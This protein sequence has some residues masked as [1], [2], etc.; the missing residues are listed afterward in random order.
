MTSPA[1]FKALG[2]PIRYQMVERLLEESPMAVGQVTDGLELTRQGA[3]RQLQV[4]V[5]SGLVTLQPRG[6]EVIASLE[7]RAL[8][9]MRTMVDELARRWDRRLESLRRHVEE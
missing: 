5:D 9:A 2:D 8:Y 3:R 4:L 1:L 7:P 6:R